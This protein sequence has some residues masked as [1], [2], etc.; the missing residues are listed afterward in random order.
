[1]IIATIDLIHPGDL[2]PSHVCSFRSSFII[3]GSGFLFGED[4]SPLLFAQYQVKEQKMLIEERKHEL[5]RSTAHNLC[6]LLN[7]GQRSNLRRS[8]LVAQQYNRESFYQAQS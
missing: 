4:F 3:P 8:R 5:Q 2:A 6:L 7:A 1:M